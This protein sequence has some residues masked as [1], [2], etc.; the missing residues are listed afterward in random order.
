MEIFEE[1]NKYHIIEKDPKIE[2]VKAIKEDHLKI[3][4]KGKLM[5]HKSDNQIDL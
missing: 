3:N 4:S 5:T 2:I 1:I